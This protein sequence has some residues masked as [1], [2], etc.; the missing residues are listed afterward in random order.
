MQCS[1]TGG[2]YLPIHLSTSSIQS[3]RNLEPIPPVLGGE[4]TNLLKG[5][6]GK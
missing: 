6:G 4:V 2:K 3:H 5:L 1:Y